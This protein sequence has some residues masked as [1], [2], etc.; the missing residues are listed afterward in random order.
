MHSLETSMRKN[1]AHLARVLEF[2]CI[3]KKKS[4]CKEKIVLSHD[5][6]LNYKSKDTKE[7]EEEISM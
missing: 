7:G 3:S 5:V 2:D 4:S 1:F 6:H